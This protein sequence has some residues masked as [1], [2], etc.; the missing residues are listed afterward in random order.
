MSQDNVQP[1]EL[2]QAVVARAAAGDEAAFAQILEA[3]RDMVYTICFRTLSNAHDAEEVF[4]DTFVSAFR[5]LPRFRGESK[6][7]T[8][9][10]R[11][12]LNRCRDFLSSRHARQTRE[13]ASLDD[14]DN[15]HVQDQL[16]T[17]EGDARETVREAIDMIQ[18]DYRTAINLHCIMGY[19]Y[20]EA[21]EL[22]GIPGGTVKTLVHRG[23]EALAEVL[24]KRGGI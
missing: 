23:K 8:W 6:L 12:A 3:H 5:N 11:I 24:R 14:E 7:S 9:L 19:S 4:Q 18:E 10:Y 22:M 1:Y 21:G 17:D 15:P 2:E 13:T 20:D 16:R